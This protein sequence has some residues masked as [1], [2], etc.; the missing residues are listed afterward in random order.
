MND[1]IVNICW[2]VFG[3]LIIIALVM[4]I[5]YEQFLV[6][7][8]NYETLKNQN[9]IDKNFREKIKEIKA[10]YNFFKKNISL[11]ENKFEIVDSKNDKSGRVYLHFLDGEYS[12]LREEK[13]LLETFLLLSISGKWPVSKKVFILINNKN[14]FGYKFEVCCNCDGWGDLDHE[15]LPDLTKELV[16]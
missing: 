12:V 6:N 3:F 5:S 14:I 7:A 15:L 4:Y 1:T 8:G 2:L 9:G 10:N 11:L 13:L 16:F